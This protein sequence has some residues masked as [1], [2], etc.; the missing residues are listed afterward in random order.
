MFE[1][2]Q[3]ATLPEEV[4]RRFGGGGRIVKLASNENP[5]G[6]SPKALEATRAVNGLN[7]Y[8]DD[9]YPDIK[10]RL[11]AA[12]RMRGENVVVGH[13]SNEIVKL[14]AETYLQAGDEAIVAVPSFLLYR[15]AIGVRAATAV[16]VPLRDGTT[17]LEGMLERITPRTKLVFVCDP[18]NPTGT[19]VTR[20]AWSA[21]LQRLPPDVV[22]VVDQAYREFSSADVVDAIADVARRSRTLVLRT[23]SKI[24]GLAAL[25]FGYGFADAETVEMLERIRLPFNVAAP[26]LAGAAAALEDRAFVQRSIANNE[27]GKRQLFPAFDAMGLH[28]YPTEAN[29]Y[30]LAVPASAT[31]AYEDLLQEGIIVRC[32]D[33]LR[34]PGRLRITIGT[35]EEN[36]ILLDAVERLLPSWKT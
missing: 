31:R 34:M 7:L 30:A 28:R 36:A 3:R 2:Y 5:L 22:L 1:S 26:A 6:T 20:E 12:H 4:R 10:E 19:A 23:M 11:A 35:E 16:E 21:F 24:Y 29:F 13:G 8:G 33:A 27:A 17:D 18:N 15:L 14:V 25:R 9:A 32:G